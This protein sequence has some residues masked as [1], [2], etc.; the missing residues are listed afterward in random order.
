MEGLI[1]RLMSYCNNISSLLSRHFLKVSNF[2][3][4]CW[5]GILLK[6][7]WYDDMFTLF[8]FRCNQWCLIKPWNIILN[9]FVI[10]WEISVYTWRVFDDLQNFVDFWVGNWNVNYFVSSTN[11]NASCFYLHGNYYKVRFLKDVY[12]YFN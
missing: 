3:A 2:T 1:H 10:D 8:T 6:F 12:K 7:K 11:Y 5:C 4:S 9:N